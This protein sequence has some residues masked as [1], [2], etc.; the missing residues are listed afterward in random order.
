[1]VISGM[2]SLSWECRRKTFLQQQAFSPLDIP[3]TTR[4]R[5]MGEAGKRDG[6]G[7]GGIGV[8][9]LEVESGYLSLS[10]ELVVS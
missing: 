10:E 1:M 8:G 6:L 3:E 2:G 9:F 4:V 7:G 5:R